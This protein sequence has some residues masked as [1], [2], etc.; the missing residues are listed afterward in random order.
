[1]ARHKEVVW[2]F[3]QKNRAGEIPD[4]QKS[5]WSYKLSW[6]DWLPFVVDEMHVGLAQVCSHLTVTKGWPMLTQISK[7]RSQPSS[8]FG[9]WC[10]FSAL[11][12]SLDFVPL[13]I[14]SQHFLPQMTKRYIDYIRS[15][16]NIFHSWSSLLV[17][18]VGSILV[19]GSSENIFMPM[20]NGLERQFRIKAS[21][22]TSGLNV[23]HNST[24]IAI[25]YLNC[26]RPNI[27]IECPDD[28][29]WRMQN[30]NYTNASD[31]FFKLS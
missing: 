29:T 24:R 30:R 12:S 7:S 18:K 20:F 1:M 2:I 28:S 8:V 19:L 22:H 14:R 13:Q 16:K 5:R 17:L 6:R 23:T 27:S 10:Y 15:S 25:N 26:K 21:M 3:P 31:L 9:Y 11:W 4:H